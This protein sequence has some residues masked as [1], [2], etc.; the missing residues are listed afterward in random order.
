MQEV[1]LFAGWEADEEI[2]ECPEKNPNKR[3]SMISTSAFSDGHGGNEY[4]ATVVFEEVSE[5]PETKPLVD[6]F[7]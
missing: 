4:T 6:F 1:K 5:E 3:I 2:Q 7:N